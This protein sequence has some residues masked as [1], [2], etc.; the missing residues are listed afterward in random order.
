MNLRL[1]SGQGLT[2]CMAPWT[3]RLM[4][5]VLKCTQSGGGGRP[6]TQKAELGPSRWWEL[7]WQG[8]KHTS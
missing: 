6:G 2:Y 4:M 3:K 8:S 1:G 7:G 5:L